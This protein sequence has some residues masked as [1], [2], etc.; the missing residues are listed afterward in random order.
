MSPVLCTS[1]DMNNP[2]EFT[3]D[4]GVGRYSLS[5]SRVLCPVKTLEL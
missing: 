1:L 2:Q 5:G 4:R 3:E